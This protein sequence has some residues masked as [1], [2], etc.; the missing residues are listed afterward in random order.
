M[1]T[2]LVLAG[3][4]LFAF[5]EN[6]ARAD[7]GCC[8]GAKCGLGLFSHAEF[9]PSVTYYAPYAYWYPNYFNVPPYSDYQVVQYT[10]PPAQT[11]AE[12]K[13]RIAAINAANPAL[14]PKNLESLPF[15]KT[16]TPLRH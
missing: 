14:L 9:V 6:S 12:I 8:R 16:G 10:T 4:L 7:D 2:S 3:L 13:A 15:P 5:G 11:A 1:I